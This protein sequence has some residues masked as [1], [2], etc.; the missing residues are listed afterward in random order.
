V[1]DWRA[2]RPSVD[3]P[4]KA[5]RE[6]LRKDGGDARD[7]GKD[8]GVSEPGRPSGGRSLALIL[9]TMVVIL[10]VL[11]GLAIWASNGG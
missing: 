2:A 10:A 6:G 8:G 3:G 9:L 5:L 4:G 11:V 1:G 7:E